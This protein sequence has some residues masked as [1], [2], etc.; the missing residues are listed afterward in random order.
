[1]KKTMIALAAIAAVGA[2]SAQVSIT[3]GIDFTYG[4]GAAYNQGSAAVQSSLGS[5]AAAA[6]GGAPTANGSVSRGLANTDAYLDFVVTEDLGGGTAVRGAI[7]LNLDGGWGAGGYA[8]DRS[9]SA[10]WKNGFS[11]ALAS[12]RSGGILDRILFAPQV[13]PTD[14]W[15]DTGKTGPAGQVI[16]RG[17]VDAAKL[18]YQLA[19]ALKVGYS[20][21]EKS[22]DGY[23]TSSQIFNTLGAYYADGPLKVEYEYG[24]LTADNLGDVRKYR[25]DITGAYDAGIAKFALG[26]ESGGYGTANNTD[27][28]TAAGAVLAAVTIPLGNAAIGMNY[29][30]RDAASFWELGATY[31]FSKQTFITA[32]YG[33][34]NQVLSAAQA[35]I[36]AMPAGTNWFGDSWGVRVGKSF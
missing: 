36:S 10:S 30:K 12:T 34:Y 25:H 7:Q 21:A 22:D 15:G 8:G 19:P 32:S 35:G 1:M 2:A 18:A 28:G 27:A 31:N 26:Y 17:G 4:K 23:N 9:F 6:V 24:M 16:T 11:A 14:H 20:Y 5:A 3:G 13:N 33:G 29:G